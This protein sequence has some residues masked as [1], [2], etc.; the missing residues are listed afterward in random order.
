[1]WYL[2]WV[3]GLTADCSN[4]LSCAVGGEA[5][6]TRKVPARRPEVCGFRRGMTSSEK[7]TQAPR[8]WV[9]RVPLGGEPPRKDDKASQQGVCGDLPERSTKLAA[10]SSPLAHRE[11]QGEVVDEE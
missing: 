4:Q 2:F 1:M 11:R 9:C 10:A 5:R 7:S 8:R 6:R 3:A